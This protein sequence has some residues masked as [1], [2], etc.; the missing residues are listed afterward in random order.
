MEPGFGL[1]Q[2]R[3]AVVGLGLM[4]GSLVMALKGCC[5]EVLGVD[6]D[7][8]TVRIA[9]EKGLVN[10][11]DTRPEVILPEA[12]LIILAVPVLTI[13]SL[14]PRLPEW[15]PQG[16]VV[17]DLGSTKSRVCQALSA[18]PESF[19]AVGGHPMC[20]K[21]L[22]SLNHAESALF[23]DAPFVL[24][25]LENTD[26][27]TRTLA[28]ELVH[29]LGANVMWLDAETHDQWVAFT[30]HFPYLLAN[31]LATLTPLEAA[32]LA[33]TGWKSTTRLARSSVP[34]MVDIFRSNQTNILNVLDLFTDQLAQVKE[35]LVNNPADLPYYLETGKL[36][37]QQVL[38]YGETTS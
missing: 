14:I 6:R 11:A 16:A 17:M 5:K 32:P 7:P 31:I 2:L 9:L 25:S 34:M 28:E 10:R 20:G 21:E 19:S 29:C 18:L 22:S 33:A 37:A 4:G 27:P 13:L 23:N 15:V 30:S 35:M 8:E 36:Q 3:V 1:K 26:E 24:V 12:D 38:S